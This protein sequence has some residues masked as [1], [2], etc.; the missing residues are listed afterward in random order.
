MLRSM[1]EIMSF[2]EHRARLSAFEEIKKSYQFRLR[3]QGDANWEDKLREF[4]LPRGYIDFV[5]RYHVEGVEFGYFTFS[6]L[7][8]DIYRFLYTHNLEYETPAVPDNMLE[9]ASLEADPI[10]VNKGA[11]GHPDN[12]VYFVWHDEDPNTRPWKIADDIEQV[13]LIMANVHKLS[14]E[15]DGRFGGRVEAFIADHLPGF[16]ADMIRR[17]REI[18][19]TAGG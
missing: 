14:I 7:D 17:W 8:G 12:T 18:S 13:V 11:H 2:Y 10:L 15:D 5:N 9:V 19:S 1:T 16:D 3:H 6:G 4:G